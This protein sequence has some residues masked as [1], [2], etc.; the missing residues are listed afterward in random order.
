MICR[1]R[2]L[3]GTGAAEVQ[4]KRRESK[5]CA[6]HSVRSQVVHARCRLVGSGCRLGGRYLCM[7]PLCI[8]R[9]LGCRRWS[10]RHR[11]PGLA[12]GGVAALL[13]LALPLVGV[14]AA[15]APGVL[16]LLDGEAQLIVNWEAHPEE[17]TGGHAPLLALTRLSC[18]QELS[19]D[20]R[21]TM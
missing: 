6:R 21:H 5:A 9:P 17:E 18:L 3:Q 11:R 12:A 14:R 4:G 19:I 10:T 2:D 20:H 13:G 16:T 7:L 1:H 15:E 8:L